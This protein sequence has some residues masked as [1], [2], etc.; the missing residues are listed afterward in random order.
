MRIRSVVACTSTL[1]ATAVLTLLLGI[2]ASAQTDDLGSADCV[3]TTRVQQESNGGIL[4]TTSGVTAAL[5]VDVGYLSDTVWS[6]M[7]PSEGMSLSD[8]G[9]MQQEYCLGVPLEVE[10]WEEEQAQLQGVS[11]SASYDYPSRVDWRDVG[12]QDW[13]TPV[14]SQGGCGSCV[15]FGTTAA[16]ESRLEIA[17]GDPELNPDLSEA[18]LFFCGSTA[19]CQTGWWPSAAMD[20]ARDT[21]VV[22]ESCYPYS[23]ETQACSVCS[24]WLTRTTRIE[25]WVGLT[26]R[27]A[28]KQTLA[29]QGPFEAVM[30]VYT[31]FFSYAGGVYR[32]I[33]GERVGAHAVTVLGYDD[34]EGYWIA[35]NSWGNGWGENGWFRIA[36]GECAIDNYAYVPI[37]EQADPLYHLYT[38]VTP[39]GGGMIVLEPVACVED[40]CESGTELVLTAVSGAGYGFTNW[41]GDATGGDQSVRIVMDSDKAVTASFAED[42]DGSDYRCFLP[43]VIG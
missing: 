32:H 2:S 22:D 41:G 20:F 24:D 25:G 30:V 3:G 12:G 36:Y 21:G 34:E 43:L 4:D 6:E 28:M 15:A 26:D 39:N 42:G 9:S 7:A 18:H 11:L 29:D 27:A 23:A 1:L 33:T 13:T 5:D 37:M 40:G 10:A 8:L 16:I 17:L 35:K 14:R 31:D 19:T 38:S